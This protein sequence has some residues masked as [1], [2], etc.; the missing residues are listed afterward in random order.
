MN[1]SAVTGAESFPRRHALTRGFTLGAPRNFRVSADGERIAFLRSSGP[2]DSVNSLWLFDV[3][4]GTERLVFDAAEIGSDIA[5]L[6]PAERVRRERARESGGGIVAYDADSDLT[7]AV[8]AIGSQIARVDLLTGEARV[9][10]TADGA[11]DP[12]LSPDTEKVAYV[13]GREL[14]MVT[15]DEDRLLIGE[16]DETV[17][18]GAA[19]FI[20]AEEMGRTRGFWWGPDSDAL[21]VQR[22][23]VAPI[24]TWWISAPVTPWESPREVRYPAAGSANAEAG[25]AI[26]GLD[27]SRV[28]VNWRSRPA[29]DTPGDGASRAS[30]APAT[31][32]V[33]NPWEYLAKVDWSRDGILLTV[34]SRDQRTLGVLDVDA[35]TGEC[36]QRYQVTDEHWVEL[37]AGTPAVRDGRLVT[38]EDRAPAR[39]LCVDGEALTGDGVQVRSVIDVGDDG[40]VITACREPTSVQVATVSWSGELRWWDNSPGVMSAVV[41]GPTEVRINRS[42]AHHGVGVEVRSSGR[43]VSRIASHSEVPNINVGVSLHRLGER[44]LAAA[45]LL[46]NDSAEAD[47]KNKLP[48]LLDPY[49]GPHAQRVQQAR[50]LFYVSQWFAD[51]G[52]AVLVTDGRGTPGRGPDFEREVRGDLAGPVL[53]DQI[54]ALHAMA[55]LNPRLDLDRV[56]IRGWSFGGYL[57]ALA[58]LRRPDVF[59]AGIA[60]APVTDWRLYDTHYTERYLGHPDSEPENYERSDV[61]YGSAQVDDSHGVP[62]LVLIHGLADDN[63][64]AAHTLQLSRAL[65][66]SGRPHTVLPLSGVT[67]MTP[68]EEVA[69]NL[70]LL[71]LHFLREALSE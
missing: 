63:V 2:V 58:V 26:I 56:A 36:Q 46:P 16:A 23:D 27:N 64:V 67:H 5:A 70:L 9:L 37:I 66:E 54:E 15:D 11:F 25:L 60:G 38:V 47:P 35:A 49:G 48:V 52:F 24:D 44:E 17:S 55:E 32:G 29:P 34:Q 42:L 10:N 43:V 40:I 71:Q 19:E 3:S 65:L 1:S 20:A 14:R 51:Q 22:V 61:L 33:S 28:D 41:G 6:S 13:A 18:W 8:F 69:E 21:L 12:R 30:A 62:P 7:V 4:A 68:Q 31:P 59:H 39:R 45:L 50:S 57:A 53:D